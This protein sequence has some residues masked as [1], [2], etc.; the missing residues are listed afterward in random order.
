MSGVAIN[1][2]SFVGCHRESGVV[3]LSTAENSKNAEPSILASLSD[4]H[5]MTI[6]GISFGIFS[7]FERKQFYMEV[8]DEVL[9]CPTRNLIASEAARRVA[10]VYGINIADCDSAK[11][12]VTLYS[13]LRAAIAMNDFVVDVP[14]ESST[15]TAIANNGH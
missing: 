11:I 4:K 1:L 5:R 14:I 13:R 3:P 15:N 12:K 2:G 6:A 7:M 9:S 8:V 10:L